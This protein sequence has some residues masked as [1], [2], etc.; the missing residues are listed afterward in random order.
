LTIDIDNIVY[1]DG[2]TGQTSYSFGNIDPSTVTEDKIFVMDETDLISYDITITKPSTI[3]SYVYN[4]SIT[5]TDNIAVVDTYDII[6]PNKIINLTNII[7]ATGYQGPTSLTV[8]TVT[9]G[10]IGDKSYTISSPTLIQYTIA[11]NKNDPS[12]KINSFSSDIKYSVS[13]EPVANA[14]FTILSEDIVITAKNIVYTTA[15]NS[16]GT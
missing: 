12:S 5:Y 4:N 16:D 7:Y 3:V 8:G 10:S 15:T 14:T 13:Q 11:I 1:Q 2:Y 6:T 9:F